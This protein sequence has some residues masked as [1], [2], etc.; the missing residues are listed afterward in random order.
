MIRSDFDRNIFEKSGQK[1]FVSFYYSNIMWK[2]T[3]KKEIIKEY[4][5]YNIE[6]HSV[7]PKN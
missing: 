1:L 2:N 5:E 3:L 6:C 7:L 4:D